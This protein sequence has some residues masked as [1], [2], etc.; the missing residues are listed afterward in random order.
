MPQLRAVPA[1]HCPPGTL[2]WAG[3]NGLYHQLTLCEVG[4]AYTD[5][6]AGITYI[7]LYPNGH[8]AHG[9]S[10]HRS[11]PVLP[12]DQTLAY[13]LNEPVNKPKSTPGNPQ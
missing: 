12:D 11:V 5:S 7:M 3:T 10:I 2:V 4:K 1:D 6:P 13:I 8:K 9:F